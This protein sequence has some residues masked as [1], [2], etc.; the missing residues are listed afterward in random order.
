MNQILRIAAIIV[1]I[2][3][4]PA[5]LN[6]FTE[7]VNWSPGDFIVAALLLSVLASLVLFISRK[8]SQ[9]RRRNL[10]YLAVVL[11]FMFIWAELAVG[12]VS[13]WI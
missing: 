11:L 12:I 4:I 6:H 9:P 13:D 8:V 1:L 5:F 10:L 3:S 7:E 2:L